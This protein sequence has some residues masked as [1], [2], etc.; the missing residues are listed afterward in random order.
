[1]KKNG[2]TLTE[3]IAVIVII[4]LIILVSIPVSQNLMANNKEDKYKLYVETVEKA[5]YTYVDMTNITDDQDI[6]LQ[7]LINEEYLKE[8]NESGYKV[9]ETLVK[10]NVNATTRAISFLDPVDSGNLKLTF[11][12]GSDFT[13]CT[14]K[15][16]S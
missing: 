12:K 4:G 1:M 2:F 3:M 16:C 13:R 11:N 6:Y 15:S 9:T 7:D 8:F 10:I 5:I 14:K